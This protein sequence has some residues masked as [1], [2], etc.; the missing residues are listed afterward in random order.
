MRLETALPIFLKADAG[1]A[2]LVAARIYG[3]L[4]PQGE[5]LQLPAICLSRISTTRQQKFCQTDTL[6]SALIQVDIYAK[7]E[8]QA[9]TIAEAVHTALVDY[10][11]LMGGELQVGPIF[12]ENSTAVVE[13]DPGTFHVIQNFTCWYLEG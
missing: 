1:I 11:G 12:E 4:R 3:L 10:R 13:P 9:W 5:P 6:V 8:S 7:G 2:A